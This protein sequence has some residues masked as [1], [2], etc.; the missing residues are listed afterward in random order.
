M[1]EDDD[2]FERALRERTGQSEGS[3]GDLDAG[4]GDLDDDPDMA[5]AFGMDDAGGGEPEGGDALFEDDFAAAFEA[6]GGPDEMGMGG[7]DE[8]FGFGGG[9]EFADEDFESD[10]PRIDIGV[11]GLDEMIQGGVPER[12]M[13]VAIGSAGTGKSTLGMQFIHRALQKG[14]RA[15]YIA[16]DESSDAVVSAADEKG[17]DFSRYA[18]SGQLAVVDFDPVE[19]VNSLENVRAELPDL[20]EEFGASR[21][22][23]DSVSLLE[24]MYDSQARRRTEIYD[25]TRGLE[26]AGVTTLLTSEADEQTSYGSRFGVIEYLTDAVLVLQYIRGDDF[27]ETRLGLEIVKIRNANH[28]REMKPYDITNDGIEVYRQANIF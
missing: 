17:W 23:L 20:V 12:S 9:E 8:E 16:L 7:M 3:D 22:V 21:L 4:D 15:V 28:S 24:M 19:M 6:A 1:S 10:I 14:E 5:E 13:M 18:D 27:R 26:D 25:F 2:W 11:D